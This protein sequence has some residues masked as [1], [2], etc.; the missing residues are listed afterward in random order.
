MMQSPNLPADYDEDYDEDIDEQP[1]E[2]PGAADE[3]PEAANGDGN[4]N[5]ST[6]GSSGP[7]SPRIQAAYDDDD[8]GGDEGGEDGFERVV[9]GA[10]PAGDGE[11]APPALA[12][13][14]PPPAVDAPAPGRPQP[15]HPL[16]S[17]PTSAAA[18]PPALPPSLPPN[19]Y[20]AAAAAAGPP[21]QQPA[22]SHPPADLTPS[23]SKLPP[24][25]K[26]NPDL[27]PPKR[28]DLPVPEGLPGVRVADTEPERYWS[29]RAHLS[30][31]CGI[32]GTSRFPGSQPISFDLESLKALE[33]EDFWVCEK[34]DGVRVLVLIVATG[35]GQ[36]V[37]LIDRKNDIYQVFW[38][39]FPH[40]DG[41][42]YNHSNTVLDGEFVIDVDP[43]TG[44]HIPR[45]LVFDLL[46]LDSE[47]VM[48]KP[49]EKRYGRLT[50]FVVAPYKKFQATVP[51]E[52]RMQQP[53]EVVLKKQE[54]SYGIEAVF[55]DHVPKLLHG[56]DGLIFTSAEA[57][58]TPGTDPKILKWKPPS[59]NSIDFLLQLKFPPR[60]DH[61]NEPDFLAKPVFMLMMNYGHEGHHYFDVMDVPDDTW[62]EWKAS[63]EQYDDRIV[64]VVWDWTR[65]TWSLMRF[66]D[67]K[68]EGN[69][70]TVVHKIIR[71]IQHGV[72]AEQLV[73]HAGYIRKA[74][75]MRHAQRQAKP[76][77]AQQRAMGPNAQA[78]QHAQQQQQ[79]APTHQY[80]PTSHASGPPATALSLK[81]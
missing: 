65:S 15:V 28:H 81:R 32:G 73:A 4:G 6:R 75:K 58:Y 25:L 72:E 31:L 13:T 9:E 38:L 40:Q 24:G 68:Y 18:A 64:E 12:S 3:A 50:N 36:E 46:V 62:E 42:E 53:F 61:P 44:Q 23:G 59:E 10:D 33:Q 47:N 39:T 52:V 76:A 74:W 66:R 26:Y 5:G 63:G 41:A 51:D 45:L 7:V 80:G 11:A 55:R 1:L 8:D 19:P 30:D 67:D 77:G 17:R 48:S 37:Y 16:P 79:S 60:S 20:H 57:P 27:H 54:L 14:P 71:S 56:N 21:P 34:S 22:P 49:L 29:L 2:L 69:F 35:F 43:A 70:K 78:H